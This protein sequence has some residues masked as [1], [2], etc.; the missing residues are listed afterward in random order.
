MRDFLTSGRFGFLA[1]FVL[2]L[3]PM[4]IAGMYLEN[5]HW[6]LELIQRGLAQY[7]PLTGEWAWKGECK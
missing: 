2:G 1:G 3:I 5:D 4:F 7:C 6:H